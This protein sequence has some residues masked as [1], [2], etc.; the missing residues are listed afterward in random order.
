MTETANVARRAR[1][2]YVGGDSVAGILNLTGLSRR[3]FHLWLKG[4]PL[5][6]DSARSLP[7]MPRWS[8]KRKTGEPYANSRQALVGRLWCAACRSGSSISL[9]AH[10]EA[11][12]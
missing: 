3:T 8:R 12:P 9:P 7:G 1:Q 5:G 2:M 6:G 11:K 10:A 4:G